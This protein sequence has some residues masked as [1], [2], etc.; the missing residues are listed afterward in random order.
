VAAGCCIWVTGVGF[1]CWPG[2][3]NW[4]GSGQRGDAAVD[5]GLNREEDGNGSVRFAGDMWI[6]W[7]GRRE[8]GFIGFGAGLWWVAV[9]VFMKE[10]LGDIGLLTVSEGVRKNRFFWGRRITTQGLERVLVVWVWFGEEEGTVGTGNQ[11]C[12][13][14]VAGECESWCSWWRVCV[15][16]SKIVSP[17]IFFVLV[18]FFFFCCV[19]GF[20]K[21][22][23]A[24]I[25][26]IW[27]THSLAKFWDLIP[28]T[29]FSAE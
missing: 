19:V 26:G 29:C 23:K 25:V 18:F 13:E 5:S 7:F 21:R 8:G 4:S 14:A 28:K 3:K 20:W 10:G 27:K 9:V 2:E 12:W 24:R 15:D 1:L 17:L 11:W 16:E 6:W 22:A